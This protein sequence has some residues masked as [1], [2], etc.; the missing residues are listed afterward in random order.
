MNNI[1]GFSLVE[2]SIVLVILGL[3]VGG[4]MTGQNLIRAAELRS[5]PEEYKKWQ[6]AIKLF[7]DKYFALPGDMQNA[8]A[9]WNPATNCGATGGVALTGGTCNGNADGVMQQGESFY[10]WH[11]LANAGLITGEFSGL[12]GPADNGRDAVSGWNVPQ[13]KLRSDAGWCLVYSGGGYEFNLNYQ[14]VISIGSTADNNQFCTDHNIFIFA[15]EEAWGLDTKLDDGMPAKG[16]VIAHETISCTDAGTDMDKM[17][18]V[19]S[20]SDDRDLCNLI[21]MQSY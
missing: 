3:L 2:L 21:F 20:L 12:T 14:N 10:A 11:H 6:I 17:D 8:T 18:A 19:Y 16:K 4:I 1:K 15:P 5:V 7:Q 9:F 13:A